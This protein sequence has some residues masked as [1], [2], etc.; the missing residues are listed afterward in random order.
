MVLQSEIDDGIH[1]CKGCERFGFD[2][3][4][5]HCGNRYVGADRSWRTCEKCRAEVATDW[6]SL[7]GYPVAD[8]T[9]KRFERGDIDIH[10]EEAMASDALQRFYADTGKEPAPEVPARARTGT[11]AAAAL[12]VFGR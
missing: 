6:C 8:E 9:L 10:A 2:R 5:G 11:L 3:F 7:C 4:C 1:Y 12:E